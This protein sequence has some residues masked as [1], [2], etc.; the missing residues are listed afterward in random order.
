MRET[1]R[2]ID[3]EERRRLRLSGDPSSLVRGFGRSVFI[4]T[5]MFQMTQPPKDWGR[6]DASLRSLSCLPT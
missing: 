1:A 5:P 2:L 3:N 4:K 6:I